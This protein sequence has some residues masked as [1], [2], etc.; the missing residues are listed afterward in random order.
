M[1]S[2]G[3]NSIIQK[4]HMKQHSSEFNEMCQTTK[5]AMNSK[6]YIS[7]LLLEFNILNLWS[8]IEDLNQLDLKELSLE[9]L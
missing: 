8:L 6:N 2:E 3:K 5:K 9:K 1:Y 7:C 4:I